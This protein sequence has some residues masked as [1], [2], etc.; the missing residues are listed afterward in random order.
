M[1]GTWPTVGHLTL[2]GHIYSPPSSLE[3]TLWVTPAAEDRTAEGMNENS[4]R[5]NQVRTWFHSLELWKNKLRSDMNNS[6][7][8]GPQDGLSPASKRHI[9]TKVTQNAA[10]KFSFLWLRISNAAHDPTTYWREN[11]FRKYKDVDFLLGN[12]GL[13]DQA[14]SV[15][16]L[17]KREIKQ[18]QKV[19]SDRPCP[20]P[21]M[22]SFCW[23]CFCFACFL[24]WAHKASTSLFSYP[25]LLRA[26]MT[27]MSHLHLILIVK[28]KKSLSWFS[29]GTACFDLSPFS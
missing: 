24:R 1:W 27:S 9:L 5:K 14:P 20:G 6:E 15:S 17:Y 29:K 3:K 13:G 21:R 25:S 4:S 26:G 12:E 16:R 10:F 2:R 18:K 7:K 19:A 23:C 28:N 22:I 8:R 11:C